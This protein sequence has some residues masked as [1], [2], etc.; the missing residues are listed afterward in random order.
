M[1][2]TP[3][4]MG[5][6]WA[7]GVKSRESTAVTVT[8]MAMVFVVFSAKSCRRLAKAGPRIWS[9]KITRSKEMGHLSL[10]S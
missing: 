3:G 10:A 6:D 2:V 5:V 1:I 7:T 8:V 9:M 4:K